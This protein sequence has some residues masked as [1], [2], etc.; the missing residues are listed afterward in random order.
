MSQPRERGDARRLSQ[1]RVSSITPAQ[2]LP[3]PPPTDPSLFVFPPQSLY[4]HQ[5]KYAF[6]PKCLQTGSV[7]LPRSLGARVLCVLFCGQCGRRAFAPR[8]P[9]RVSRLQ[10]CSGIDLIATVYLQS[11]A[12]GR[13][14]TGRRDKTLLTIRR[15]RKHALRT[16]ATPPHP[17]PPRV[18]SREQTRGQNKVLEPS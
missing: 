14:G 13:A 3:P 8:E 16:K 6:T 7:C 1:Q 5:A 12:S 2:I 17:T 15:A 18:W 11:G 4:I 10:L 9:R